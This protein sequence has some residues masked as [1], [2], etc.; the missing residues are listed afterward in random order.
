MLA[1]KLE[2]YERVLSKSK[3]LA[4]PEMT[5]ADLFY[6]PYG[7][8]AVVV[9]PSSLVHSFTNADGHDWISWAERLG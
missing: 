3:Y 4:G 2:G 9:G 1:K 5:L 8:Q 6:L 7:T